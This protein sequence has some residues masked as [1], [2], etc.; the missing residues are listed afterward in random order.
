MKVV[1]NM[2]HI[3]HQQSPDLLP[4][5]CSAGQVKGGELGDSVVSPNMELMYATAKSYKIMHSLHK[6]YTGEHKP[7]LKP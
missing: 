2:S 4:Y 3:S 6:T 7:G 1:N 5:L